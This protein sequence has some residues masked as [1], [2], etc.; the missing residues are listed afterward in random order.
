MLRSV[1]SGDLFRIETVQE[2]PLDY[3][4]TTEVARRE[5]R[6]HARPELRGLPDTIDGYDVI[7]LGFPNWWGTP[8]MAVFTFLE[9]IDFAGKTIVPFCT[10]EGSG[11][12]RSESDIRAAC[13]GATVLDGLALRGAGVHGAEASIKRW[14]ES[15]GLSF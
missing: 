15:S 12:G 1:T 6:E 14:I 13:P 9:S 10:H 5:L 4:E 3:H 2:Y 7:F 8:P 11:L